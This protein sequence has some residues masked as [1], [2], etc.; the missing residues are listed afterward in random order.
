MRLDDLDLNLLRVFNQLMVYRS[1]SRV[2]QSLGVSQPSVSNA[3]K[4]LRSLLGDELFLRTAQGMQPT[5]LAEHIAEPIAE[6]IETIRAAVGQQ[7]VFDCTQAQ[8]AFTLATSDIGELHLLPRLLA[9]I[10]LEAPGIT[11]NTASSEV[12]TLKED[13]QSG[14]TDIALGT[15]PQLQGGY[16]RQRLL[17]EPYVLAYR[18]GHPLDREAPPSA[19]DVAAQAHLVLGSPSLDAAEVERYL[20]ALGVTR[21]SRASVTRVTAIGSVLASTDLVAILPAGVVRELRRPFALSS[22]PL[23]TPMADFSIELFWH[24]RLHRDP[25]NQWLRRRI[26][27]LF[28]AP[29]SGDR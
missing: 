13:L 14:R 22:V 12:S 29:G 25:A 28:S 11:L 15:L 23:P 26:V 21:R 8:R 19:E 27:E 7:P 6:A 17:K 5:P 18:A 10:G 24:A 4:R 1:V 9:Q 20:Q 2:A 16:F 3:L